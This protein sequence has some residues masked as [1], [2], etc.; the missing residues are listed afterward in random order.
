MGLDLDFLGG[1]RKPLFHPLDPLF[2]GCT[3][4]TNTPHFAHTVRSHQTLKEKEKKCFE[5]PPKKP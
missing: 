1:G 4:P 5:A 2:Y 3:P